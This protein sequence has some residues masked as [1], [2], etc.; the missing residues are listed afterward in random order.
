[1]AQKNAFMKKLH[2]ITLGSLV[3]KQN[4]M[5]VKES[6]SLETAVKMM[7]GNKVHSL[8]V[9]D[10]KGVVMGV[11]DMLD[12]VVYALKVAP[13][14]P[15]NGAAP[16][17]RWDGNVKRAL[18]T[19]ARALA[20]ETVGLVMNASG[21]DNYVPLEEAEEATLAVN[22]FA[23]GV[24]R[25]PILDGKGGLRG[26]VSQSTLVQWLAQEAQTYFKEHPALDLYLSDLGL[27]GA[28]PVTVYQ[29]NSVV[30]CLAILAEA[31]VSAVPVVS[32]A[33]TLLGNFSAVD[34]VGL[35]AEALPQYEQTVTHFLQ[36][37]S[38]ASLQARSLPYRSTLR[39]VLVFFQQHAFHRV[40][41]TEHGRVT[42][43]VSLTDLCAFLRDH[44]DA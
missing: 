43:V 41:V 39:E 13:E 36:A 2:G 12:V 6:D 15:V 23:S 1:M 42:G 38:P 9:V 33:G 27:G 4:V 22:V 25:A 10:A 28:A 24:H 7:S 8:P 31:G 3:E 17:T 11:I 29:H 14:K 19:A 5:T 26:T 35:Y 16:V 20:L 37:H 18:E 21:K 44:V 40:W 34:L 32:G 30:Q